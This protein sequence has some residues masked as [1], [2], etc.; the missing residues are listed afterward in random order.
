MSHPDESDFVYAVEFSDPAKAEADAAYLWLGRNNPAFAQQWYGG[1]FLEAQKL[2]LFPKS[3][4]LAPENEL[5]D[6]EVRQALYRRGRTTYRIL[7]FLVDADGDGREDAAR[8]LH[9]LHSARPPLE[10]D[11]EPEEE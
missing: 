1:L 11:R 5:F 8:I 7:F 4:P 2:S 9:V 6:V 3:R 10:R